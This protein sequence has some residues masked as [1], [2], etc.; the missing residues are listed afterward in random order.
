MMYHIFESVNNFYLGNSEMSFVGLEQCK[1]DFQEEC[2][3]L[4]ETFAIGDT[5]A[6]LLLTIICLNVDYR[7]CRIEDIADRL[8][9]SRLEVL[10]HADSL[11][12]LQEKKL[13]ERIKMEELPEQKR[14]FLNKFKYPLEIM[15]WQFTIGKTVQKAIFPWINEN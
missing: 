7:T 6:L 12:S 8:G 1:T 2:R 4:S 3:A 11:F 13:I 9:I 5:E 10:N 14:F 15:N